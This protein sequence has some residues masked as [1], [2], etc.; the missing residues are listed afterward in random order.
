M[1]KKIGWTVSLV[2][3]SNH[4]LNDLF[5]VSGCEIYPFETAPRPLVVLSGNTSFIY[6][7][8]PERNLKFATDQAIDFICPGRVIHIGENVTDVDF[9]TGTCYSGTKFRIGSEIVEWSDLI[10]SNTLWRDIRDTGNTCATNG[11]ELEAGYSVSDDRFIVSM[12]I[13]FNFNL[14]IAY[15]TYINQTSAI[16]QRV[17]DNPRPDWLQGS[18]IY[19]IGTVNNLFLRSNQR[20]TVNSLL[21][22]EADSEQYIQTNT[23]SYL[24]RG[25][26]TARS[27]G[28][29]AAQQNATFYMPNCAPQWQKFNGWNW[30]QI[31]IDVRNYAS[32]RGV[33][34]QVLLLKL[35]KNI[36]FQL[37]FI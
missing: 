29:Y 23:D 32:D 30:N 21:G 36:S 6:P 10:C 1:C 28:Y 26:I 5:L 9:V 19:T 31:E 37:Y 2:T 4:T 17:L 27:D 22:L 24:A 15:Y 35:I 34:L 14:Q 7:E 11:R 16:F 3:C 20:A 18:G 8:W 33:D 12:T 25:H 13:C